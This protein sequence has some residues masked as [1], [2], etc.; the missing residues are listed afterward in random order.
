MN[1]MIRRFWNK[2]SYDSDDEDS[3]GNCDNGY[4]SIGMTEKGIICRF[5]TNENNYSST[6][7]KSRNEIELSEYNDDK[8]NFS[9]RVQS[10][11]RKIHTHDIKNNTFTREKKSM[12]YYCQDEE[13]KFENQTHTDKK[14]TNINHRIIKNKKQRHDSDDEMENEYNGRRKNSHHNTNRNNVKEKGNSHILKAESDDTAY[15]N[16]KIYKDLNIGSAQKN[17]MVSMLKNFEKIQN[18]SFSRTINDKELDQEKKNVI[19]DGDPM[20][21]VDLINRKRKKVLGKSNEGTDLFVKKAKPTYNGPRPKRNRYTINPGYRWDAI[22]RGNG[23]EE[24]VFDIFYSKR[25][26]KENSYIKSCA[27]M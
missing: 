21:Y 3:C 15:K 17:L 4:R 8:Y 16:K 22:D 14:K 10:H 18:S 7:E 27:D 5:F 25:R 20:A 13:L 23:F 2:K 1:L 9:S 6:T 26:D 24:K 12:R 11:C 19:R